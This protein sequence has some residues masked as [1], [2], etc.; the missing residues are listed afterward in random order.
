MTRS[1]LVRRLAAANP[2]LFR[3]DVERIVATLFETMAATLEEGGRIELRGFGVMAVRERPARTARNPR[4]GETVRVP[5][6]RTVR[7]R[8]GKELRARL[9]LAEAGAGT[10]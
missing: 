2:H 5:P 9:D 3:R 7:F 6:R 1:E 4:T 10:E 8:P